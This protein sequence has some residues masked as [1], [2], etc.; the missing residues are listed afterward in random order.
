MHDAR[1][2]RAQYIGMHVYHGQTQDYH[3]KVT[4]GG[5]ERKKVRTGEDTYLVK[6][7][8][9]PL[10]DRVVR[11]DRRERTREPRNTNFYYSIV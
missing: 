11:I 4:D 3:G 1:L 2:P 6:N 5:S 9:K 7:V 10:N 8:Y